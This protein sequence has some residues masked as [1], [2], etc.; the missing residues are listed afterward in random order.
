MTANG[1]LFLFAM[2]AQAS[3]AAQAQGTAQIVDC[4]ELA[5]PGEPG[6]PQVLVSL[7]RERRPGSADREG[8][9][10]SARDYGVI[11]QYN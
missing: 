9:P 2:I 7:S 10:A 8:R 11:A 5:A 4:A 3:A 1:L 6:A